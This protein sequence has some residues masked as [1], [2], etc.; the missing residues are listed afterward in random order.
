MSSTFIFCTLTRSSRPRSKI[1]RR[2]VF[3]PPTSTT[4]TPTKLAEGYISASIVSH[5]PGPQ[6]TSRTFPPLFGMFHSPV[7]SFID[8]FGGDRMAIIRLNHHDSSPYTT[9]QRR[10]DEV[11]QTS[12]FRSS[13]PYRNC[14]RRLA[15]SRHL[16]PDDP[17]R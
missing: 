11:Y 14:Q 3:S 17:D 5:T 2:A 12:R 9:D 8:A 1:N 7:D 15:P 4:S 10:Y 16:R 6:P 13:N